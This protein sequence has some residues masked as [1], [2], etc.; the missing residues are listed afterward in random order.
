MNFAA[1]ARRSP[2]P[3]VGIVE[4]LELGSLPASQPGEQDEEYFWLGGVTTDWDYVVESSQPFEDGED[5]LTIPATS[6]CANAIHAFD[7]AP[8]P[9][10]DVCPRPRLVR[11]A[12][13]VKR[14]PESLTVTPTILRPLKLVRRVTTAAYL[15][16][17]RRRAREEAKNIVKKIQAL[18]RATARLRTRHRK[19]R[20][21]VMGSVDKENL[22][23]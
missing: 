18:A 1:Y 2:S 21:F 19:L 5:W 20:A 13:P 12:S 15:E 22:F 3:F 14:R 23:I 7:V 8:K 16:R 10:S 9:S 11:R 17:K 6:S 4:G